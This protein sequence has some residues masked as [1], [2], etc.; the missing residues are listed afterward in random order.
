MEP[1]FDD[2]AV[3]AAEVEVRDGV[4]LLE[5]LALDGGVRAVLSSYD[6]VAEHED[7]T[8]SAVVGA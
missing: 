3:D 2:G 4:T 1:V 7:G 8:G 5:V 6:G